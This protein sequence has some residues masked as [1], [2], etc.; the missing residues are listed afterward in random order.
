MSLTRTGMTVEEC[1]SGQGGETLIF[2]ASTD[3]PDRM[4]D[5]VEQNFELKAFKRNPVFLWGHDSRSLPIGKIVRIW[6]EK[7]SKAAK[8]ARRTLIEVAFVPKDVHPFAEQVKQM[9]L[10]GF[11]RAV[12][13]G[14]RPLQRV[15]VSESEREELG[16]GRFGER[17]TKSEL[18]EVSAVSI[19][20]NPD[21]LSEGKK[22][23]VTR[24]YAEDDAE[25]IARSMQETPDVTDADI[26]ALTKAIDAIEADLDDAT[27]DAM[28][29][30]DLADL[31]RS[32]AAEIASLKHVVD[33]LKSAQRADTAG[34]TTTGSA[35]TAQPAPSEK[36]QKPSDPDGTTDDGMIPR[37][38]TWDASFESIDV[39]ADQ[40]K[41]VID[42]CDRIVEQALAAVATRG[43]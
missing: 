10:S 13:I 35:S 6:T 14:F 16:L 11:M 15:Q 19:P 43:N 39:D 32:Q 36:S 23:L 40:T 28:T 8:S 24:G 25:Q 38:F 31:V 30:D 3:S 7:V 42:E 26:E 33:Q 41:A 22:A 5:I 4:G 2:V 9:Y 17:F 18:L 1:R 20:A 34:L 29:M 12:S 21:A 27:K 37:L